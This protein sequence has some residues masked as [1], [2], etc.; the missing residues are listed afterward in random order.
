MSLSPDL[1]ALE[2]QLIALARAYAETV[3]IGRTHGQHAE[4]TTFG[5]ALA[6]YVSRLGTRIEEIHR[7]GQNL[8]GQFSGAV[9]A[10]NGLTLIHEHPEQIEADF[11]AL[12]GLKPSDTNTSTQCVEPE[13]IS[14]LAYQITGGIYGACELSRMI[15]DT[16]IGL[17]S[18]RSVGSIIRSWSAHQQ[19]RIR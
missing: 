13:F 1:V 2:H 6:L 4:P 15:C 3:Q 8:R 16:S 19:C 5:Y 7:A 10:F 9:G 14:D 11:L 17:K 18:L 12:L